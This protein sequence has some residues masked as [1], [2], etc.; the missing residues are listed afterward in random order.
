M[1]EI[2]LD[3]SWDWIRNG[4]QATWLMEEKSNYHVQKVTALFKKCTNYWSKA[5][6]NI[7]K[8]TKKPR[9][10]II[11]QSGFLES[12]KPRCFK[13]PEIADFHDH[14][15]PT[16]I[17]SKALPGGIKKMI[18]NQHTQKLKIQKQAINSQ[19]HH[20]KTKKNT[21]FTRC[22]HTRWWKFSILQDQK[23]THQKKIKTGTGFCL[24]AAIK[25]LQLLL[26]S[27]LTPCLLDLSLSL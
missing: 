12:K 21:L 20:W 27:S 2:R 11:I 22:K 14:P 16:F 24:A 7:K 6:R 10:V 4:L 18:K 25:H 15:K 3:K 5:P 9:S 1:V 13:A 8:K 23:A 17:E 26:V 19:T